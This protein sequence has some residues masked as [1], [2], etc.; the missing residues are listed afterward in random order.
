MKKQ[1]LLLIAVCAVLSVGCQPVPSDPATTV[2]THLPEKPVS[3]EMENTPD[4]QKKKSSSPSGESKASGTPAAFDMAA[5]PEYDGSSFYAEINGNEPFFS[6][7]EKELAAT[8]FYEYSR[9]D[10]MGR[11]GTA[12]ACINKSSL[13]DEE[14]NDGDELSAIYPSGW[15]QADYGSEYVQAGWLYN[16]SHLIGWALGGDTADYNIVTATRYCNATAMLWFEEECLSFVKSN[17][18]ASILYRVTPVFVGDNLT[19]SGILMECLS[20][21]GSQKV[22]I[23]GKNLKFCV[24]VYNIQPGITIDYADG[25]SSLIDGY[26]GVYATSGVYDEIGDLIDKKGTTNGNDTAASSAG[27]HYI[28]NTNSK[29]IHLPDCPSVSD[30]SE[31]NKEETQETVEHLIS[32]GYSRCKRCNP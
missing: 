25:S 29:K 1:Y 11:A 20:V 17:P 28:L 18:K 27:F 22:P 19:C 5:I 2:E 13:P 26:N 23:Y 16:R 24:F 7:K 3:T 21:E 10:N 32:E 14:R 31:K 8:T 12:F 4:S 9:P 6:E 30:M 15:K